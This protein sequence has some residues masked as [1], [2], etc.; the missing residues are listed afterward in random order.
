MR[1]LALLIVSLA[2]AIGSV[3]SIHPVPVVSA[4]ESGYAPDGE[5]WAFVDLVN[6]YRGSLGIGPLTF[7]YELGAAAEYHSVD[8]ATNNYFDHYS[9]NGTDPGTNIQN[10]GYTGFP[11]SENIAA[12]MA[13]AQEVLIGWQ[14]SPEHNATM[15]N[16]QYTEIGIGRHYV[17]G[18]HYG[19]YWTATYGAGEA[20][21]TAPE[22][23]PAPVEVSDPTLVEV[24]DPTLVT[25]TIAP[26]TV[27]TV[28]EAPSVTTTEGGVV[29]LQ[30]PVVN[31]DGDRAVSTGGNPVADGTGDTIIYGDIN[32]GGIQ[33]ETIVY[34]EPSLNVSGN[35]SAP[36]P[37]PAPTT[38]E[39][40]PLIYSDPAP[41]PAPVA[42]EPV[43]SGT[44]TTFTE[45]TTT[46]IEMNPGNGQARG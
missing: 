18:S 16:P 43:Y 3:A 11:Y 22:P 29:E 28:T 42:G 36:A 24:S 19:W 40:A 14:N 5:E 25:E 13:T 26:E 46:V 33:G 9:L 37:A 30:Q 17:E 10:F 12:G 20:P 38:S 2:L 1:R 4:Q 7:N 44:A 15:T 45:T 32:T 21:Q 27:T 8:M 39:P 6:A 31:A 34:E 23:L 35:A 41:A